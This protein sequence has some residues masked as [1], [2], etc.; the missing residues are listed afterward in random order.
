MSRPKYA[1]GQ[2][3]AREKI[4]ATFWMMIESMPYEQV[5]VRGLVRES[6]VNKNTFYY[7]FD[8][9]ADLARQATEEALDPA[10]LE[11]MVRQMQTG[12]PIHGIDSSRLSRQFGK[13]R[14][15][16]SAKG[17]P[18]LQDMLKAAIAAKWE[19]ALGFD[20][21]GLDE[22]GRI[23]LEFALGGILAVLAYPGSGDNAIVSEAVFRSGIPQAVAA[24]LGV[25][26]PVTG[27]QT[28]L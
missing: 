3:T 14:A 27:S 28:H 21:A 23:A 16:A 12:S 18:E 8:D 17:T 25:L 9:V 7:H 20:V 26:T 2:Q 1:K 5:S 22:K 24:A 15:I 13:V 10:F 4:I 11:E 6:G 19:D